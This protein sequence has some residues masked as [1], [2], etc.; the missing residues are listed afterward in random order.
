MSEHTSSWSR[1]IASLEN[2]TGRFGGDD[3]VCC[4]TCGKRIETST[5]Q[6]SCY[7]GEPLCDRC[8]EAEAATD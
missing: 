8:A 4:Q 7:D 3:T 2:N 6:F 5:A 1:Y